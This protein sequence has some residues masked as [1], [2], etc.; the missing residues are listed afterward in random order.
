MV[1]NYRLFA[2]ITD[3]TALLSWGSL[4]QHDLTLSKKMPKRKKL[5][6]Y[7]PMKQV[8]QVFS[9]LLSYLILVLSNLVFILRS[10]A[11]FRT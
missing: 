6:S 4:R 8:K 7:I 11:A 5:E 1:R 2:Y 9:S 3:G 10:L